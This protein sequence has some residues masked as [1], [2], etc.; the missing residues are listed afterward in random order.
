MWKLTV[1]YI[2]LMI[3]IIIIIMM[4]KQ[5]KCREQFKA[6]RTLYLSFRN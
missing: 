2:S 4:I 1:S 5:L 3:M 6:Y